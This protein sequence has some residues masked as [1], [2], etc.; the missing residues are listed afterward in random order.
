MIMIMIM[1]E[2][3]H[4]GTALLL[5]V[6]PRIKAM[7]PHAPVISIIIIIVWK[8]D[9]LLPAMF[10]LLYSSTNQQLFKNTK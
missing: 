5:L 2:I 1:I 6:N 8:E 4:S 10:N 7:V 9:A 3:Q